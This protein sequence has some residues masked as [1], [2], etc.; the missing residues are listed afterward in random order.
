MDPGEVLLRMEHRLGAYLKGTRSATNS[1]FL[2]SWGD[3]LRAIFKGFSD[4]VILANKIDP[5]VS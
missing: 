4:R 3:M 1:A 5:R 2:L